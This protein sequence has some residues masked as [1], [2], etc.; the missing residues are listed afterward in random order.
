MSSI[1]TIDLLINTIDIADDVQHDYSRLSF[2]DLPTTTVGEIAS[3]LKEKDYIA[4]SRTNS[5]IHGDCT[6][7]HRL[8]RLRLNEKKDYSVLNIQHFHQITDLSFHLSKITQFNQTNGQIFS[9]CTRLRSMT[10]KGTGGR[11][12]CAKSDI[13]CL[14]NDN[15]PCFASIES[16]TLL[17]VY[18]ITPNQF[19]R[20]LTKFKALNHLQ[21][22][23]VYFEGPPLNAIDVQTLCPSLSELAVIC[24]SEVSTLLNSWHSKLDTLTVGPCSLSSNYNLSAVQRLCFLGL[25]LSQID[26]LLNSTKS[27]REISLISNCNHPPSPSLSVQEMKEVTTRFI[28]DQSALEYLY[29]F[30]GTPGHFAVICG[31]IQCGLSRSKQRKR[32][33]LEIV[34]AVGAWALS[35]GEVFVRNI[36]EI[37]DVLQ[38]SAVEEWVIAVDIRK[39]T[40][41]IDQNVLEIALS[42]LMDAMKGTIELSGSTKHGFVIASVGCKMLRHNEWWQRGKRLGYR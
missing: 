32:E 14:V 26:T 42:A 25:R 20:I 7:V 15:S 30:S 11:R 12:C 21:L 28:V 1:T 8:Q 34:L 2:E 19:T 13:D 39:K 3:Y 36:A 22:G 40:G 6:A 10:I 35:D 38:S 37:I 17:N 5:K 33:Q 29:I 31:A 18:K 9:G 41:K 23:L 27:L 24:C 16:L 4:F